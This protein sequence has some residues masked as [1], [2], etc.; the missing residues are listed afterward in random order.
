MGMFRSFFG[1]LEKLQSDDVQVHQ[2]RCAVVRNR[3]ASCTKC[4]DACTSG[5]ISYE[6]NEL[7]IAPEKCIGCGTCATVCPTCAL[8]ARNPIDAELFRDSLNAMRHADGEA[9]I[10]C[11]HMLEK[12]K[13]L[14]DPEKVT[15]VV[16]LGRVD[17]SLIALL[18]LA[19]GKHV[20]LVKGP[21]EECEYALG[22]ATAEQVVS[23]AN[24]LLEVWN[25]PL[26]ASVASKFPSVARKADDSDKLYDASR[27]EFFTGVKDQLATVAGASIQDGVQDVLGTTAEEKPQPSRYGKVTQAGVLPQHIPVRRKR[28]LK[29][30]SEI[31]EPEDVM[32][33]TRLWGHVLIDKSKCKSCQM[34]ATFCPTGAL[35]RFKD[36]DGTTGIMQ[37]P[38]CCVK[39]RCCTDICPNDALTISDEVSAVGLMHGTVE[40]YKMDPPDSLEG[41]VH[42]IRSM[43]EKLSPTS[44]VLDR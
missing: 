17:E 24:G 10:V 39:C 9:I 1:V 28:L 20:T 32:L 19:Q 6:D 38:G 26:R 41:G 13:G 12:T 31:G 29:T 15:G 4:A 11:R 2:N 22:L 30:L 16:C 23:T 3:H 44:Q 33:R 40:K 14:Y 42:Q 5:C 25:N 21:C 43:M 27:R 37:Y 35:T 34:C 36:K 8:E 7:V 18:A